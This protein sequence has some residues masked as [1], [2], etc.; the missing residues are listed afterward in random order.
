M[1]ADKYTFGNVVTMPLEPERLMQFQSLLLSPSPSASV[2]IL[3]SLFTDAVN[4]M[5]ESGC[6]NILL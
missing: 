5:Y 4:I 2:P 1:E 3:V 6:S